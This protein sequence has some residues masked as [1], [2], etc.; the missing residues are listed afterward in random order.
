MWMCARV[1]ENLME[2][3]LSRERIEIGLIGLVSRII[4]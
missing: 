2:Q 4:A 3:F 1:I